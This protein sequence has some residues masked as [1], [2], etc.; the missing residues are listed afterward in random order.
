MLKIKAFIRFY[1]ELAF[2]NKVSLIFTLLFPAIYQLINFKVVTI[3]NTDDFIQTSMLMI[4]YIIV[5]TAINGVTMSIISTRNSGY[6]KAYYYASGSR[7]AIYLANLFVQLIIVLLE[8]LIFIVSLMILYRFFSVNL[9]LNFMLMT[10]ISF[11]F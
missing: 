7:W 4:A 6:I 9:L 2:D 1:I 5:S 3:T 8:N 10:L 11:P